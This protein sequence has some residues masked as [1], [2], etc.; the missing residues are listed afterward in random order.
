MLPVA[1]KGR[2]ALRDNIMN[3]KVQSDKTE[4][5][6]VV[7]GVECDFCHNLEFPDLAH[8][9]EDVTVCDACYEHYT[10]RWE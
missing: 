1:D 5:E 9:Y 2:A 7:N 4:Y 6:V 8:S 10:E 3:L